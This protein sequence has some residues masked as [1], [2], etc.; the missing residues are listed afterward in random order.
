MACAPVVA[1]LWLAACSGGGEAVRTEG[2]YCT[3]VGDRLADLNTTSFGDA[4]TVDRVL[5]SWREVSLTA[6]LAVQ[7]EWERVLAA[8]TLAAEVDPSDAEAVQAMADS[9][10]EAQPAADRVIDYTYRVCGAVIG[11]VAPVITTP[12]QVPPTT[13]YPPPSTTSTVAPPASSS[14]TPTTTG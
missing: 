6:P 8:I 14:A 13:L 9:L 10:R 12:L 11:G 4:A 7:A 2:V 1:S 3:E 5:E